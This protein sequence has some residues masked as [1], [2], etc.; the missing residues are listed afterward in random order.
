MPVT[1]P[2]RPTIVQTRVPVEE[3][4][5]MVM[6]VQGVAVEAIVDTGASVSLLDRAVWKQIPAHLRPPLIEGGP[7]LCSAGGDTIN[8]LGVADLELRIGEAPTVIHPILVASLNVPFLLGYDFLAKYDSIL[9]VGG[10]ELVCYLPIDCADVP[11]EG[12]I[13]LFSME[14]AIIPP[15]HEV[16]V[17]AVTRQ[18]LNREEET[19]LLE[20]ATELYDRTGLMVERTSTRRR[21]RTPLPPSEGGPRRGRQRSRSPLFPLRPSSGPHGAQPSACREP[22]DIRVHVHV[23]VHVDTG[24][25]L[26]TVARP[27]STS[28]PSAAVRRRLHRRLTAPG[29]WVRP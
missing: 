2:E 19:A 3:G 1:S 18:F 26:V 29:R 27:T 28:G 25:G 6:Y 17:Y 22:V 14:T 13:T 7:P 15:A 9:D 20:G 5:R 21:S 16:I 11:K 24:T 10:G 23:Y 8:T 12:A 4:F